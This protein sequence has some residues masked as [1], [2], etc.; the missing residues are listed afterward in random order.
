MSYAAQIDHAGSQNYS[1]LSVLMTV[2]QA[3]KP[4]LYF[5]CRFFALLV[6]EKHFLA[7]SDFVS[8]V[9]WGVFFGFFWS[10]AQFVSLIMQLE[11]KCITGEKE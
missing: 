2:F 4:L 1:N 9:F 8:Q 6:L 10:L 11:L 5:T 7:T 3:L